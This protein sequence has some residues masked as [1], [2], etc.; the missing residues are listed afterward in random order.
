MDRPDLP[1]QPAN[2][3]SIACLRTVHILQKAN[4]RSANKM[5]QENITDEYCHKN[6]K[7]SQNISNSWTRHVATRTLQ[8]AMQKR[9][10]AATVMY[11]YAIQLC[12]DIYILLPQGCM[13]SLLIHVPKTTSFMRIIIMRELWE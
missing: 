3:F 4:V 6:N 8:L 2:G 1:F 5:I 11:I 13:N 12:V 10:N 9:Q 7:Y